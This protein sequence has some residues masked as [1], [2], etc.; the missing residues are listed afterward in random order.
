VTP[1]TPHLESAGV[2]IDPQLIYAVPLALSLVLHYWRPVA[3][4]PAL[5][6]APAG[7]VSLALGLAVLVAAVRGFRAAGTTLQPWE[8]T[9]ALVTSGPFRFSRNPI[10][11]G[12][13]LLYLGVALWV[14][15][16]WSL[17]FLPLVLWGMTRL[18]I[19]REERY[20]EA[21]FGAAYRDYARRV[22][23]WI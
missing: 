3:S 14:R 1:P 4:V 7:L 8:S 18:V 2:R 9:T 12:Y 19:R 11:L 10:Y 16:V 5:V 21:R 13:T 20:L 15:S 22:R 6:G 17:V 23:R